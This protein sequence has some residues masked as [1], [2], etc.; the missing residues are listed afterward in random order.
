V[1]R[2]PGGALQVALGGGYRSETFHG[3]VPSIEPLPTVSQGRLN[4]NAYGEATVPLF[5]G[6]FSFPGMRRLEVSFA[7]R[8]DPYSHLGARGNSKWGWSWEPTRE[9]TVRGTQGTSFQAPLI[10]QLDAPTTSYTALLPSGTP[11]GKPTDA[12]VINGGSQYTV[13]SSAGYRFLDDRGS[14]LEGKHPRSCEC[15]MARPQFSL[16]HTKP[17]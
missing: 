6:D 10:S 7:Y 2:L 8:I 14:C 16:E 13:Q 9:L 3:S 15:S 12:L 1:L 11:G 4:L 5:G 17:R